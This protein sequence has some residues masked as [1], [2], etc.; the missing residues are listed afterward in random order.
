MYLNLSEKHLDLLQLFFKSNVSQEE[1]ADFFLGIDI[2]K[3]G[4]EKA[5]LIAHLCIKTNYQG[6]PENLVPR[7]KG[8]LKFWISHNARLMMNALELIR[9]YN[10]QE[11]PVLLC[12]GAAMRLGYM[13]KV[14]RNMWDVDITVPVEKYREAVLL[15]TD[16][17][18]D[19]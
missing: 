13:P 4:L 12:K 16:T 19:A 9:T 8:I 5:S 14:S 2:E 6:V 17:G 11:I 3:Q 15:A 10:Q 7:I 1:L 18:Y